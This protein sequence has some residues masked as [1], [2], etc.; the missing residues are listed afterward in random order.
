MLAA[1]GM[2]NTGGSDRATVL[3]FMCAVKIIRTEIN[4][5]ITNEMIAT[6]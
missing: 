1:F 4:L 3:Q 2:H 6:G 5:P